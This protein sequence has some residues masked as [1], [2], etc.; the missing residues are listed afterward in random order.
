MQPFLRVAEICAALG[1]S[2]RMLRSLC[3]EHLGMSPSG[4]IRLR[5]MQQVHRALRSGAISGSRDRARYPVQWTAVVLEL[6]DR[7][8]T[9]THR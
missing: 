8:V 2:D 3:E 4:Y 6:S 1:V 5:R 7:A 9:G